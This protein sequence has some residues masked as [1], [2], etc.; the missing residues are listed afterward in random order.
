MGIEVDLRVLP[1]LT[2]RLIDLTG[3]DDAFVLYNVNSIP[4]PF[5]RD[6]SLYICLLVSTG[7][8]HVAL[9][10]FVSVQC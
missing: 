1:R 3:G 5:C 6:V 10:F 9:L 7:T 4:T 8:I 2:F